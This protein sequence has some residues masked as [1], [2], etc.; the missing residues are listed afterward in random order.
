MKL[1]VVEDHVD[2]AELLADLLRRRGH[3]VEIAHT[4]SDALARID[5]APFELLITDV[6]LPDASGYDLMRAARARGP[7]KGIAMSGWSEDAERGREAGFS[8]H[9]VKP[10]RF[11]A[12][13]HAI[14]EA[15]KA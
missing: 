10:V 12:L 14:G 4:V 3:L 9:L 7:I 13:E 1:L 8:A 6:G 5:A 15:T 2:T 11:D